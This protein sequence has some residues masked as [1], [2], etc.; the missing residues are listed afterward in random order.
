MSAQKR[1]RYAKSNIDDEA[2]VQLQ[3]LLYEHPL[4]YTHFA[5]HMPTYLQFQQEGVP[6]GERRE[7]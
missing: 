1:T 6:G 4:Q 2:D 7:M 3:I 5:Q